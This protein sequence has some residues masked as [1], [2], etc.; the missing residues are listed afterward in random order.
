MDFFTYMKK[1]LDRRQL[2]WPAAEVVESKDICSGS[3][4]EKYGD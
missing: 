1:W 2:H 4:L 3:R